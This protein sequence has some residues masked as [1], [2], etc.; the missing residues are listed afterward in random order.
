ME[1]NIIIIFLFKRRFRWFELLNS[2]V[3]SKKIKN[4]KGYQQQRLVS[5]HRKKLPSLHSRL[6]N[7]AC[8]SW[9]FKC[10]IIILNL[11]R[12]ND[13][14]STQ[15]WYKILFSF[16][17]VKKFIFCYHRKRM[18]YFKSIIIYRSIQPCKNFFSYVVFEIKFVSSKFLIK[19]RENIWQT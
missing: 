3:R 14:S 2:Q 18:I 13:V 16:S 4:Q 12:F 11:S 1:Q 7:M 6:N 15:V 10:N 8:R 19:S 17:K 5:L 9:I